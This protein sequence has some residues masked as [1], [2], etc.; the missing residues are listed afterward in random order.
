MSIFFF[1]TRWSGKQI[2]ASVGR[3]SDT[4]VGKHQKGG[5][6]ISPNLCEFFLK[7]CL[8]GIEKIPKHTDA[9]SV[10]QFCSVFYY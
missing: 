3:V 5:G 9:L 7:R 1:H 8:I 6:F 10:P 4:Q 2:G